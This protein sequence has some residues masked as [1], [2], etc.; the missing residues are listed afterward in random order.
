MRFLQAPLAALGWLGAQG[1]RALAAMVFIGIALPPLGAILKPY[2]AESVFV[3]LLLAFLRVEPAALR[4]HV[5]RPLKLAGIVVWT[6]IVLPAL[7]G[8]PVLAVRI[9]AARS[10]AGAPE[11][12]MNPE[13]RAR[14]DT[15]L[16]EYMAVQDTIPAR[17]SAA[18]RPSRA[19]IAGDDISGAATA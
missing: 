5:E 13:Q 10:L 11:Q 3:L 4:G 2:V 16:A 14:L 9:E 8:D 7:L 6:M 19:A 15:V 18:S 12:S 1:T 17:T